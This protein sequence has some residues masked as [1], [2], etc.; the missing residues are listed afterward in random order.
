MR[1]FGIKNCGSVQKARHF[2]DAKNIAYEFVDLKATKPDLKDIKKWVRAQG[3]EVVLN[4]KGTT[5]K[6]L[7]LKDMDLDTEGKIAFCHEYPLL[8][9]RPIIDEFDGDNVV[10]GF[11]SVR[12]QEIFG[13]L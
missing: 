5:Y 3:I 7:G 4:A 10:V 13:G 11:D 2:L 6:R 8:L 1:L 9:K 12:Y